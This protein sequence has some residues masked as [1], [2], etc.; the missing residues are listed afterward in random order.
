MKGPPFIPSYGYLYYCTIMYCL[1]WTILLSSHRRTLVRLTLFIVPRFIIIGG[2]LARP[3]RDALD[4]HV[5]TALAVPPFQ[6]LDHGVVNTVETDRPFAA[7]DRDLGAVAG[8]V[9][10]R[11]EYLRWRG[12]RCWRVAFK[13]NGKCHVP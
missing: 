10:F 8:E 6:L 7:T 5:L 13:R 2:R 12:L 4:G 9:E 1:Y 3:S 11:E